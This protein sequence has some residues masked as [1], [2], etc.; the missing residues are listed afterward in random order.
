MK[1]CYLPILFGL[2]LA[3]CTAPIETRISSNGLTALAGGTYVLDGSVAPGAELVIAQRLVNEALSRKGYAAADNA[4]L[5]LE[6]TLSSRPAQLSLTMAGTQLAAA[7]QRARK[8][9]SNVEYRL[10]VALTR[11]ADGVVAYQSSAAE[12][13]CSAA[14]NDVLPFLVDAA[15]AD[16]G[17]PAGAYIIRRKGQH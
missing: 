8:G 6:V 7:R 14:L 9:C 17:K 16:L 12:Y 5:N 3:A 10:G 15:L 2:S 1:A 13:H 4:E 11:I